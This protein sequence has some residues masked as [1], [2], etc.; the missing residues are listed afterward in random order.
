MNSKSSIRREIRAQ[1]RQL[2]EDDQ[3]IAAS[4]VLRQLRRLP[5]FLH[6]N[7]VSVYLA[8]DGELALDKAVDFLWA[9]KKQTFL[10]VLFGRKSRLMHFARFHEKSIFKLNRF[11][12]LEPNIKIRRQLKPQ[13]LDL[14]LLPL[15]AFD[16][17][18][19]RI[20]MGGGFY[21]KTLSY[22]SHRKTWRKPKLIGIAYDFQE[23]ENLPDDPW[24]VPLDY[25]VTESRS[26]KVENKK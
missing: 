17:N 5:I 14:V 25:I 16:C 19:N 4:Y 11:G 3:L 6:A 13:Q 7:R 8:N 10:P 9:R 23:V 21:D 15:V 24:D 22:L 12:I 2:P 20:G 18:G 1:R 26:I